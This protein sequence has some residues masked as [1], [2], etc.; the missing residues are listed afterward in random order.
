MPAD[1]I[2]RV[3]SN[4]AGKLLVR[5]AHVIDRLPQI[6]S[7]RI[8][9]LC[10]DG[11]HRADDEEAHPQHDGSLF[12]VTRPLLF[13]QFRRLPMAQTAWPPQV[14]LRIPR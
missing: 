9:G 14:A 13:H 6:R 10:A 11:K 5:P 1:K 7:W 8:R 4:A 3:F 12:H 2:R